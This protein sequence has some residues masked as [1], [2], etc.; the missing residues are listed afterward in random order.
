MDHALAKLTGISVLVSLFTAFQ[1]TAVIGSHPSATA[2]TYTIIQ[3]KATN[4]NSNL[5][6]NDNCTG[7]FSSGGSHGC[8]FD[9]QAGGVYPSAVQGVGNGA[10]VG[11]GAQAV[12]ITSAQTLTVSDTG[13]NSWSQVSG[14]PVFFGGNAKT[15]D[16]WCAY[17]ATGS[18]ANDVITITISNL[19]SGGERI[20][21]FY[22]EFQPSNGAGLSV[23]DTSGSANLASC[24]A[25]GSPC[26]GVTAAQL[27]PAMTG[28]TDVAI[29]WVTDGPSQSS[30]NSPWSSNYVNNGDHTGIAA[31]VGLNSGYTVP[32]FTAASSS[33]AIATAAYWK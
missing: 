31:A 26:S 25:G 14:F 20:A 9:T 22:L 10:C 18:V 21:P 17:N 13:G 12:G 3:L 6:A 4:S 33:A 8:H 32:L 7:F 24:G 16:L 1:M 28:T 5:G 19:P 11:F 15:A 2:N 30:V 27:S 23:F 29:Q